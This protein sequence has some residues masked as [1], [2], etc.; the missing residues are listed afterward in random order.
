M[1]PGDPLYVWQRS[2]WP[3]WRHDSAR[4]L[5]ALTRV[6]Q[7]VGQLLGRLREQQVGPLV[8]AQMHAL[9]QDVMRTSE[10][11]GELLRLD[12]VR[13]SLG[14][15]LGVDVG[16]MPPADQRIEGL[17]DVVM[18]ATGNAAAPLTA[19]RLR[20]WQAAL[21]PTGLSGLASI[22]IGQWR[23][24]SNGPMQVV[25]GPIQRRRVHYEAPPADRLDAE[26][27]RFLAWF[28]GTQ[29]LDPFL[30]AGLAHLWFEVLHP[31]DDG[32]G[33]V[34]RAVADMALARAD[35]CRQRYYSLSEQIHGQ[36]HA[37]YALLA[38]TS[39]G[40]LDANEWLIWFLDRVLDA[41]VDADRVLDRVLMKA[42]FWRYAAGIPL[43]DRQAKL[44]NRLLDGFEGRLTNRKWTA[45][46]KCSSDTALR[47]INDLMQ[48]G[49]L[50][51][52]EGSGRS[53]CYQLCPRTELESLVHQSSLP[54]SIP[55]S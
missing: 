52:A 3:A 16:A 8:H 1:S 27:A 45:I 30:K 35:G 4:L 7:A 36:R 40:E 41:L 21:F 17:V 25:S 12:S 51:R 31:F 6:H 2:D 24:D 49:L 43:N 20:A 34:G 33:R 9:T 42:A 44:L 53:T 23:D 55:S 47:D 39:K 29:E 13:S 14:R 26:I 28:N 46:A 15:R 50:V 32:N 22:R 38:K 18:D 48:K 10:I 19:D 54:P 5:P 37:Y 11:E